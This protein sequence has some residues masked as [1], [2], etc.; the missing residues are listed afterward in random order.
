M[1]NGYQPLIVIVNGAVLYAAA[2]TLISEL[3]EALLPSTSEVFVVEFVSNEA[4]PFCYSSV[5][6]VL[7]ELSNLGGFFQ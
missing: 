2:H 3:T 4:P 1:T 6:K 7:A 5:C